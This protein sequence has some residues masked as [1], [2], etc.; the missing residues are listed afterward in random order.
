MLIL[1]CALCAR[2]C[3]YMCLCG[4]EQYANTEL[5]QSAHLFNLQHN[6]LYTRLYT[7]LVHSKRSL[8]HKVTG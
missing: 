7:N 8:S 2:V 1:Y 6:C 3:I 5:I 4:I